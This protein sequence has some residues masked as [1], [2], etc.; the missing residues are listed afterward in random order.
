[1][2]KTNTE[3]IDILVQ[4][5]IANIA[6][7]GNNHHYL[8][9]EEWKKMMGITVANA[10]RKIYIK[11]QKLFVYLDSPVIKQEIIML[12]EKIRTYINDKVPQANLKDI[13]LR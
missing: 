11:D 7:R 10:T 5:V 13:V 2:R 3:R 4:K 1:M 12:K 6:G 8:V 9:I